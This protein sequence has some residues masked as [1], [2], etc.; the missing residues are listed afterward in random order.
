VS[1]KREAQ[2]W[3]RSQRESERPSKRFRGGY[4][5]AP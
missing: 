4:L 2:S 5:A 3:I 1:F